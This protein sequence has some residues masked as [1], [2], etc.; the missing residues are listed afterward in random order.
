MNLEKLIETH[1]ADA[2]KLCAS[3]EMADLMNWN[4]WGEDAEARGEAFMRA[5]VEK[6]RALGVPPLLWFKKPGRHDSIGLLAELAMGKNS[7]KALKVLLNEGGSIWP[8]VLSIEIKKGERNISVRWTDPS[9]AARLT[10]SNSSSWNTAANTLGGRRAALRGALVGLEKLPSASARKYL[11]E[12]ISNYTICTGKVRV[13]SRGVKGAADKESKDA[14][15][16]L[17]E[18][19]GELRKATQ[20]VA[21]DLNEKLNAALVDAKARSEAKNQKVEEGFDPEKLKKGLS[22]DQKVRL[23]TLVHLA[24][25]CGDDGDAML[26]L[27]KASVWIEREPQVLC[28]KLNRKQSLASAI[29]RNARSESMLELLRIGS[30]LWLA[31]SQDGEPNACEWVVNELQGAI[32]KTKKRKK[33]EAAI[34]NVLLA[35]SKLIA[36]GAHLDGATAPIEHAVARCDEALSKATSASYR[37]EGK[38]GLLNQLRASLEAL[39]FE[40]VLTTRAGLADGAGLKPQ[41]RH[42]V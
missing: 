36:Y 18:F 15:N 31:A 16:L 42:R 21:P 39:A 2:E 14:A 41:C 23:N 22:E 17:L 33:G 3:L 26:V 24:S 28:L 25:A 19:Q 32:W 5:Y 8:G 10:F 37:D 29:L 11:T 38:L 4:R 27:L 1:A 6:A 13:D 12:L 9:D 30:N 20:A 40:E 35:A 7:Q 34:K